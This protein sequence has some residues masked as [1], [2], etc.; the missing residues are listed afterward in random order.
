LE[1]NRTCIVDE[2][3]FVRPVTGTR[4]EIG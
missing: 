4:V 1:E 3:Y 2:E